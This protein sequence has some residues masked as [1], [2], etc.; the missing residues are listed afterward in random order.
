M[1]TEGDPVWSGDDSVKAGVTICEPCEPLPWVTGV[2]G[3]GGWYEGP[4]RSWGSI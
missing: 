4:T 2:V 3:T 1:G